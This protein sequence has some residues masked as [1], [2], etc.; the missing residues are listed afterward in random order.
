MSTK[1]TPNEKS[2]ASGDRRSALYNIY[3]PH[4]Y[5]GTDANGLVHH[6]NQAYGREYIDE[7][8]G[9]ITVF[10]P[11][12]GER[13]WTQSLADRSVSEWIDHITA[14]RGWTDQPYVCLGD[15]VDPILKA[16]GRER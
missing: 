14:R 9:R 1:Q 5:V 16:E 2:T 10:D 15:A 13:V 6:Y 3:D 11:E 7:S 8:G 4:A 12:T